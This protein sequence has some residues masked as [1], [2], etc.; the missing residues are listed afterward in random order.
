MESMSR[1]PSLSLAFSNT[2]VYSLRSRVTKANKVSS[3]FPKL[4]SGMT[5]AKNFSKNDN[6]LKIIN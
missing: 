5:Q 6:A 1:K 4:I 2:L 3:S